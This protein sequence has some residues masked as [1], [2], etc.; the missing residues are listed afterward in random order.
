MKK[1]RL[2]TAQFFEFPPAVIAG[3]TSLCI[4]ENIGVTI[5]NYGEVLNYTEKLLRLRS[6]KGIIRIEGE[7]FC[8]IDMDADTLMASGQI[9]AVI[10]E[11][12]ER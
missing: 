12:S 9:I 1:R 11:N 4:Y 2:K 6:E 5:E 3:G 10:Y 7:G 8:I